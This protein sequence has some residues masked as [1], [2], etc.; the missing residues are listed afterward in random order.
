MIARR[1]EE[2]DLQLRVDWMNNPK[3]YSSMHFDIPVKLENTYNWFLGHIG[4]ET[5]V[6]L[7][8]EEDGKIVAFG[9]LT[10][11]NPEIKKA[12]LYIFVDPNMQKQGYGLKAT[13]ILCEYG[14]E[15]LHLN[16]IY[17]YVNATNIGAKKTYEKIGFKLE[18]ILRQELLHRGNLHDR[19]Y[20]GLLAVE[21]A[22]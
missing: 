6:D 17:L 22:D 9:G 15:M 13:K 1:L 14:F 8:F 19:L 4:S 3:V 12:E 11:I 21:F 20:Y 10:S 5:R 7:T 16:K 2:K 18:G